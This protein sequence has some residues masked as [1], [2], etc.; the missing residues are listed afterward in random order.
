M[1]M[2]RP[3]SAGRSFYTATTVPLDITF[4]GSVQEQSKEQANKENKAKGARPATRRTGAAEDSYLAEHEPFEARTGKKYPYW[5]YDNDPRTANAEKV[6][7]N[8]V[9][10]D[11]CHGVFPHRAGP[12]V[13]P[14]PFRQTIAGPQGKSFSQHGPNPCDPV[15][16]HQK[17]SPLGTNLQN[18]PGVCA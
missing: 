3:V 1:T 7:I 18:T 4:D 11:K 5:L 14:L 13:H 15:S 2:S 17:L 8:G 16:F 10:G 12:V 9:Y 6:G